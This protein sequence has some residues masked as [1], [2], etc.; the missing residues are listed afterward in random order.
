MRE[1][2]PEAARLVDELRRLFGREWID[3][4]LRQ[5]IALQRHVERLEVQHGAAAAQ[6]WLGRQQ[7]AG[8]TLRLREGPL[9]VGELPLRNPWGLL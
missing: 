3:A 1:A 5:G 2:M 6:A 8:A 4:A 7:P 9:Q